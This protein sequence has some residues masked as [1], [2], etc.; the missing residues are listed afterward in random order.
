MSDVVQLVT[1]TVVVEVIRIADWNVVADVA[2]PD[3]VD[4]NVVDSVEVVVVVGASAAVKDTD[5]VA[6]VDVESEDVESSIDVVEVEG[7]AEVTD[8][9]DVDVTD[10]VASAVEG[11]GIIDVELSLFE[12]TI[13][14]VVELGMV[15]GATVPIDVDVIVLER[16]CVCHVLEIITDDVDDRAVAVEVWVWAF[17]VH[18]LETRPIKAK[19]RIVALNRNRTSFTWNTSISFILF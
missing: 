11:G 1:A 4:A 7:T 16:L 3:V 17:A 8:V 9:A 2:N 19:T 13:A 12:V 15:V 18:P 6:E 14:L 10:V 5:D